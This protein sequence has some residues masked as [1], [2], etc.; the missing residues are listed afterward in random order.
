MGRPWMKKWI[1]WEEFGFHTTI[2]AEDELCALDVCRLHLQAWMDELQPE[3]LRL[4]AEIDGDRGRIAA[5]HTHLYDRPVP[6]ND[7]S[8]LAHGL[9]LRIVLALCWFMAGA[10][11]VGNF[12]GFVLAGWGALAACFAAMFIT[13]VPVGIGH[14]AY[15]KIVA[16]SRA[17]QI[18]L[19]VA[20]AFLG[21]AAFYQFGQWRRAVAEKA[22]THATTNSYVDDGMVDTPP[23]EAPANENSERKAN[24]LLGQATLLLGMAA[25]LALGY[26]VGL[27]VALRTDEDYAAWRKVKDL[28]N[29]ILNHDE[30]IAELHSLIERAKKQCTAGIRRAQG[31]RKKKRPPYH[32]ALVLVI[33]SLLCARAS[34]Q[35]VEGIL[36]D[37]SRSVARN[38]GAP[39]L[40][41]GYL[42]SAKRL[43][44]T[45]PPSNRVS[46][47]TIGFDSFGGAREIVNGW[48]P[49]AH[50]IFT[51]DLDRARRQLATTF[52][53]KSAGLAPT[54]QGTDIFG[55]LW[56]LKDAFES[57]RQV[58]SSGEGAKSIWIFS[59]MMNETKEFPMPE[60]L[61]IGPERMLERAKASGLLVP[62]AHYT[63]HI[64]GAS[65]A[66]LTPRS[67]MTIRRFWEIY[68]AAAGADLVTYSIASEVER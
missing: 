37:T 51:D 6:V 39:D 61:G 4:H 16:G 25:E 3:L 63:V 20:I 56:H 33:V 48:T 65:P 13:A 50:G 44:A 19:I 67:W 14:L 49:E 30:R 59:D 40:F 2:T 10:G 9:R 60:L 1:D 17:L 64:Y 55:G 62:L 24:D 15:E 57:A 36:I 35:A 42:R 7:A 66:G 45:E 31:K 29:Q 34:S 12:T 21:V 52:E 5:L 43:L 22:V 32:K 38:G 68:F 41:Q 47:S 11:L 58:H 18:A 54:A 23:A 8:M 28:L 27:F 46:V 53:A 26:L